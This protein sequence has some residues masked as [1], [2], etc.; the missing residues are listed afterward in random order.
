M[1]PAAPRLR[2]L[3]LV[4]LAAALISGCTSP[5]TPKN[6]PTMEQ[7]QATTIVTGIETSAEQQSG[8]VTAKATYQNSLDAHA[9]GAITITVKAGAPVDPVFDKAVELFW[10]SRLTPLSTVSV[11]VIDEG[12]DQR[13]R[14]QVVSFLDQT[15]KNDLTAKYG[16]RPN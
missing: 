8:V 5:V 7:S 15:T 16:A 2:T 14:E 6:E 11:G 3:A 10:R 13:G 4:A 1:T 12:D 9:T